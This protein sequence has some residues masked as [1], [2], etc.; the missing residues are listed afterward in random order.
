MRLQKNGQQRIMVSCGMFESSY[1]TGGYYESS[2]D[3]YTKLNNICSYFLRAL[4]LA[5]YDGKT[6]KIAFEQLSMYDYRM[7]NQNKIIWGPIAN[8]EQHPKSL[9]LDNLEEELVIYVG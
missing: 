8:G 7:G 2:W 6:L 5:L 3:L 9:Y 1:G 4:A